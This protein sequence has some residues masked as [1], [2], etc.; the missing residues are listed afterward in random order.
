MTDIDMSHP[1]RLLGAWHARFWFSLRFMH[2]ENGP[3]QTNLTAGQ[4]H[5]AVHPS[6]R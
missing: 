6:Q 3:G 1:L 5:L 4:L 2:D